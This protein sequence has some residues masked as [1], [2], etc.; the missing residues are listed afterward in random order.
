[1]P[2]HRSMKPKLRNA[3]GHLMIVGLSEVSLG[4]VT[5]DRGAVP[6]ELDARLSLRSG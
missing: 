1:M 6:D 2:T 4:V 3:E 5:V